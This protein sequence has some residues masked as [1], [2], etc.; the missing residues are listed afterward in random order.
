MPPPTVS[1]SLPPHARYSAMFHEDTRE[2][3]VD[4][5]THAANAWCAG[6][7]KQ[8]RPPSRKTPHAI[9]VRLPGRPVYHWIVHHGRDTDYAEF[10]PNGELTLFV[11]SDS[12][13]ASNESLATCRELEALYTAV[14]HASIGTRKI[15][16]VHGQP[17]VSPSMCLSLDP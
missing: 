13:Q 11:Y 5:W 9:G 14:V 12:T 1:M 15:V 17:P 8:Y 6:W 3:Y 4:Y 10:G 7:L 16:H 2:L